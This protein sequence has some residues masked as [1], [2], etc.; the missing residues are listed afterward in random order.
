MTPEDAKRYWA[1]N[2]NWS[3]T[4]LKSYKSPAK[5]EVA[6]KQETDLANDRVKEMF[7][8]V[9]APFLSK[10]SKLDMGRFFYK[11][12]KKQ[13]GIKPND[14]IGL[15]SEVVTRCL[16]RYDNRLGDKILKEFLEEHPEY[17]L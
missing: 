7:I 6:I 2:D 13:L 9:D 12:V 14:F 1:T 15:K 11:A 17:V 3:T 10:A 8:M 4:N 5:Y 16:I